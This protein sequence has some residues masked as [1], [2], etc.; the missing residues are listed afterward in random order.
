MRDGSRRQAAIAL[1][2]DLLSLAVYVRSPSRAFTYI[3]HCYWTS[4][5]FL[6]LDMSLAIIVYLYYIC[7]P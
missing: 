4:L 2:V 6:F 1:T 3:N 5:Y 7:L